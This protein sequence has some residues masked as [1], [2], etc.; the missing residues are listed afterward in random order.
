MGLMSPGAAGAI[1][2][3]DIAE[4]FVEYDA[5]AEQQGY[6][7]SLVL[8]FFEVQEQS[9]NFGKINIEETLKEVETLRASGGKYANTDFKLTQD[10]Y[11]T[12][13]HGVEVALDDRNAKLYQ[14]YF[15]F[16]VERAKI[17]RGVL[18]RNAEKRY[19]DLLFS[20]TTFSGLT[21][22][23]GTEWSTVASA[24]VFGDVQTGI[25]AVRSNSGLPGNTMLVSWLVFQHIRNNAA[26]IERVKYSGHTDPK[27]KQLTPQVIADALGLDEIIIGGAIRNGAKEGQTVPR[28]A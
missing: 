15:D 3:S 19:A 24:D 6:V 13:E 28:A 11:A 26:I 7:G 20:T 10:N 16:E 2:R 12:V 25:N 4:G 14:R 18:M 1:L 8:P 27:R 17:A 23:V 21:Q 5:E 9:A 22:D